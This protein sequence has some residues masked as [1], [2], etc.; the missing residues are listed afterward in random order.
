M[1]GPA[2]YPRG[3]VGLC[4]EDRSVSTSAAAPGRRAESTMVAPGRKAASTTGGPDP[5]AEYSIDR[6]GRLRASQR[7]YA[8]LG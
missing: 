8:E 4:Q 7:R 6:F 3:R 2:A 5:W 1:F